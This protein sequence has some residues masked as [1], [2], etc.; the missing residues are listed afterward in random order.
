MSPVTRTDRPTVAVVL[1]A[2]RAGPHLE[3]QLDSLAAQDWPVRVY[4]FDDASG[5]ATASRLA[6]HPVVHE[7]VE[8]QTNLGF[9][10][11]FEAGIAHALARG[12]DHVALAD[13]DDL[14]H[15]DR[16]RA[17]MEPLLDA[18]RERGADAPLLAHSDLR[19]VDAAGRPIHDS[20]LARRGYATGAARDLPTLLGQSGVMGNT[21]L[22]NRALAELA[23]PF[24]PGLF[25]HDW[26]LGLCAEL[27][28][29]RLFVAR[30]TVDYRLH[31]GNA[32]N[33]AGTANGLD[34]VAPGV[35]GGNAAR[36]ALA[37]AARALR[38]AL[39]HQSPATLLARDFRL[40][41]KEDGRVGTLE[42]LL[43][44]DG[45]RP[46]LRGEAR[47][48]V[49]T[50]VDYL[51]LARP[52]ATLARD[53]LGRGYLRPAAAHRLRFCAALLLTRRYGAGRDAPTPPSPDAPRGR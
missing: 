37:R 7:L 45:H 35:A 19:L 47:R 21:V 11:N 8:R 6:A 30:A 5:D 39:A 10:G 44:G 25:V 46:A 22:F 34:A 48:T 26:W 2:W 18:E 41:F 1:C 14:W 42:A 52:R 23:L 49:R 12:H 51:R 20:F 4:A 38:A 36:R 50:F 17:G 53:M 31:A 13:Q 27:F 33:P 43:A 32:S 3:A 16:V 9:V 24:P 29:T 40:P 28:G 15:P